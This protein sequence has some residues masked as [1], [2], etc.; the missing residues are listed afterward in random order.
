MTS[1]ASSTWLIRSITA[2]SANKYENIFT[3]KKPL[4]EQKEKN[5]AVLLI[6]TFSDIIVVLYP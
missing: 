2:L 1:G 3:R 4:S 6:F 5:S